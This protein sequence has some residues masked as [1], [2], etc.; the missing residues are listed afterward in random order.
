MH[1]VRRRLLLACGWVVMLAAWGR[2]TADGWRY[3]PSFFADQGWYLQVAHRL[4]QGETLYRDV[5][6]AYGPWPAYVQA[7]LLRWFDAD[8][9]IVT[10]SNALLALASI[11]LTFVCLRSLLSPLISL[12]LTVF[13]ALAGAY[14]GGDLLRLHF[15]IYTQAIAWGSVS[16]LLTLAAIL[17]WQTTRR[18]GWLALAAGACSLAAL[19]KPEATLTAFGAVGVVLWVGRA[20]R[21]DWGRFLAIFALLCALGVI[22]T[23]NQ[24][25]WQPFWRGYTG[26]DQLR[27][28]SLWGTMPRSLSD[29]QWLVGVYAWWATLLIGLCARRRPAQ[30]GRLMLLAGAAALAGLIALL[31]DLAAE[32]GQTFLLALRSGT[33]ATLHWT[34][35]AIP[36]W[37]AAGA[38]GPIFFLLLWVAWRVRRQPLP[39]AWWGLWAYATLANLR[40][41]M[42]G[43]GSGFA[44]GP[45][46]AVLWYVWV[47]T[48][49]F[50]GVMTILPARPR[51][52]ALA[53]TLLIALGLANLAGQAL[54]RDAYF[55]QP[56][57]WIDT[58]LG[59]IR[60]EAG[61][62]AEAQTILAE[63]RTSLTPDE[64]IFVFGWGGGWYLASERPNRTA[65]DL[66]LTGLGTSG[67]EAHRLQ[68][69]LTAAP[70][71]AV[72][73]SSEFW[74]PASG[75]VPAH[76]DALRQLDVWQPRLQRDYNQKPLPGVSS[77]MLLV[78]QRSR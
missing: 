41:V 74:Q 62:A 55:N 8:A 2:Q 5:A 36:T 64:T 21:G 46:L 30:R 51:R 63:L 11:L 32:D 70:P 17:R 38:W 37:I 76:G 20:G 14:I 60:L 39:P 4:A 43:Y 18:T 49:T 10:A 61:R 40:F 24:A 69:E 28:R 29:W 3:F 23:V 58:A 66:V 13:A 57:A 9:A 26:Y 22:W 15:Y 6:W 31:P 75:S 54:S 35:A 42:T 59:P 50:A 16:G 56:R 44:L 52:R 25:G 78:R 12:A 73:L 47:E 7:L 27:L 1:I 19:N 45:A 77:W 65:F 71:S 34:P 48:E 33:W 72:I 53:A 68:A 67:A